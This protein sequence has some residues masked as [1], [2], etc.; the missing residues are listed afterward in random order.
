MEP[1]F[2]KHALEQMERRC[3]SKELVLSI[4]SHPDS[5]VN[6]DE[7]VRI[8]SKLVIEGSKSYFYRVFINHLKDPAFVIT[9]YKTSKTEKYGYKI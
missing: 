5:I 8:Y 6:Q 2:S 9:A 3:I 7:K 1:E 4:I